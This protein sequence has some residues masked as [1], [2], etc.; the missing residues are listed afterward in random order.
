MRRKLLATIRT[1]VVTKRHYVEV[2]TIKHGADA[3]KCYDA[4][5]ST[6]ASYV[7]NGPDI[8]LEFVDRGN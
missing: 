1:K 3:D 7:Y 8:V 6:T 5:G 4:L 2:V